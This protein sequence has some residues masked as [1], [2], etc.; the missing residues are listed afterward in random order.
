[1]T[2]RRCQQITRLLFSNSSFFRT[3]ARCNHITTRFP[4]LLSQSPGIQRHLTTNSLI[5]AMPDYPGLGLDLRH[6]PPDDFTNN[7]R[8]HPIG[9]HGSCS[10]A[11]S[12]LLP[13][14]ELAMMNIMDRLTDKE[15][16]HTKVFDDGIVS[17]W[18]QEAMAIPDEY[19]NQLATRDKSHR[20]GSDGNFTY[21]HDENLDA[22]EGIMT[23][24]AF[25]FVCSLSCAICH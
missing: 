21:T 14:R 17:K 10:Q 1:M 19:F 13:I 20:W 18:R 12:D 15:G 8:F 6:S 4:A 16:W 7:A 23:T 22:L 9:A 24:H 3:E 25:N 2:T 5:S 11:Q